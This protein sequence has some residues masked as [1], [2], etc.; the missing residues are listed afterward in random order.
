MSWDDYRLGKE[1]IGETIDKGFGY[2]QN[3]I[4]L[5]ENQV[6]DSGYGFFISLHQMRIFLCRMIIKWN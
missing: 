3:F 6:Y 4:T 1:Y 2:S 5:P